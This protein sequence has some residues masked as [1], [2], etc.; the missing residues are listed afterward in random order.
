MTVEAATPPNV[1]E[2]AL[3]EKIALETIIDASIITRYD[4]ELERNDNPDGGYTYTPSDHTA[5]R[6]IIISLWGKLLAPEAIEDAFTRLV[7]D[8]AEEWPHGWC[9]DDEEDR[10]LS[11]YG[12]D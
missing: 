6:K 2:L 7:E 3:E 4:S 1:S 9:D 10:P 5:L 12:P 8:G 11:S